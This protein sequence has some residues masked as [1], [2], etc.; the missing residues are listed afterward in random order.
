MVPGTRSVPA[1]PEPAAPSAG[2]FGTLLPLALLFEVAAEVAA[3][4]GACSFGGASCPLEGCLWPDVWAGLGGLSPLS[5]GG[6]GDGAS[7]A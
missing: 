3:C 7:G 5:G 1:A 2:F 4:G 6:D